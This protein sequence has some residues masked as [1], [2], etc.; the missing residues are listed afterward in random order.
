MFGNGRN[1][2][3]GLA[4]PVNVEPLRRRV[5]IAQLIAALHSKLL[6]KIWLT[7]CLRGGRSANP[8]SHWPPDWKR[9]PLCSLPS[10]AADPADMAIDTTAKKKRWCRLENRQ[11]K[12]GWRRKRKRV[13]CFL[14]HHSFSHWFAEGL[15]LEHDV[16]WWAHWDNGG[17]LDSKGYRGREVGR[18][19][20]REREREREKTSSVT[21]TAVLF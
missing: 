5:L 10:V 7:P 13:L 1:P 19:G 4:F 17:A 8:A 16:W 21:S 18:E 20:G 15:Y 6:G 9:S 2:G 11:M 12:K 14:F 3:W